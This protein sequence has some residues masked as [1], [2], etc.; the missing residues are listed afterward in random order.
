MAAKKISDLPSPT[1]GL[2]RYISQEASTNS[3]DNMLLQRLNQASLLREDLANTEDRLARA[4]A[5]ELFIEFMIS[6]KTLRPSTTQPPTERP[7]RGEET[8]DVIDATQLGPFFHSRQQALAIRRQQT[9]AERNVWALY[10]AR[11]GC[12]R[13]DGKDK[14][15]QSNGLCGNCHATI[16]SRRLGLLNGKRRCR[17]FG[18]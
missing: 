12:L 6:C 1:Q 2:V 17:E 7:A 16:A 14:P 15:H 8:Q 5:E 3:L 4:Q 11:Y 9:V 13:C 10:Y 18:A